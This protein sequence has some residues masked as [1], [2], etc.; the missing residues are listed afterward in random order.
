[1]PPVAT[2]Y[3]RYWPGLAPDAVRVMAV[4]EQP[5]LSVV[6]GAVGGVSTMA[7]TGVRE[8]SQLAVISKM[9]T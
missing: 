8:L 7:S 2:V 1:V 4:P 5:E 9:E 6:V 3:H